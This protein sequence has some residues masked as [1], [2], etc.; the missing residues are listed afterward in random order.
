[1]SEQ[2]PHQPSQPPYQPQQ[3]GYPP[4]QQYPYP[5]PAFPP[6][7]PPKPA[8]RNL[9]QWFQ[10]LNLGMK[11]VVIVVVLFVGSAVV[12][13]VQQS[14]LG[15]H[16]T[17]P[18]ATPAPDPL[19]GP[20]LG[21][22]QNAFDAKYGKA[23]NEIEGLFFYQNLQVSVVPDTHRVDNMLAGG[24]KVHPWTIDQGKQACKA[25]FPKDAVYVKS[26][27]TLDVDKLNDGTMDLYTSKALAGI[28]DTSKF[29]N[30]QHHAMTPGT[31]SVAYSY[32]FNQG[33]NAWDKSHYLQC[34]INL[35]IPD[36]FK[37][38]P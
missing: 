38:T 13:G 28:F 26:L 15:S 19:A 23:S 34:E 3:Q 10:S 1:M 21:G 33:K 4:Q 36:V 31:F 16:G 32:W 8:Q 29:T 11:L 2:Y 17:T 18:I 37:T 22:M 27:K 5:Q 12:N 30:Q 35:G 9:W 25:F 14:V 7:Q 24:P 20:V 6:Q